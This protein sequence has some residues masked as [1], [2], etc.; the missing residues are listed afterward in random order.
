MVYDEYFDS[1]LG[2]TV[3]SLTKS[4]GGGEWLPTYYVRKENKLFESK[5]CP[6]KYLMVKDPVSGK[7]SHP[8]NEFWTKNVL[9]VEST[10]TYTVKQDGAKLDLMMED[11]TT[12]SF[13]KD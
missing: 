8:K 9:S 11:G 3:C 5:Y 10:P 7:V 1:H 13:T 6:F 4:I 2:E 12:Y